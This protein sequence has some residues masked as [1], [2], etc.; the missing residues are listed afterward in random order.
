MT[1]QSEYYD[2]DTGIIHIWQA[3]ILS[4][5]TGATDAFELG[6]EDTTFE[7][8]KFKLLSV[9][10]KLKLYCSNL[11]PLGSPPADNNIYAF[12]DEY[13]GAAGSI[14]VG[15]MNNTAT[16]TDFNDLDAFTGTSAWPV[17]LAPYSTLIGNPASFS[18]TWKPRK[19]ALSNEQNAFMVIRQDNTWPGTGEDT[20]VTGWGSIYIRGVRL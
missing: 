6:L 8:V 11:S 16:A 3:S 1:Q 18:K 5:S 20:S 14:I 9:E 12:N 7:D 19:V 13:A 15:V 10:Y 4:A 2:P 17:A